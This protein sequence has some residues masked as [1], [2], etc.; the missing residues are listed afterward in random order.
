M[1]RPNLF[2]LQIGLIV[3]AAIWRC[4]SA[5]AEDRDPNLSLIRSAW[6]ERHNSIKSFRFECALEQTKK[7]VHGRT[8][9]FDRPIDRSSPVLDETFRKTM[10]YSF[11]KGKLSLQ[12]EG[13]EWDSNKIAKS[14]YKL[15]AAFS[16]D[17]NVLLFGHN[18]IPLAYV[19]H[20]TVADDQ[21][22]AFTSL[23]AFHLWYDPEHT[24]SRVGWE[25][26]KRATV[27]KSLRD[28][29]VVV[30]FPRRYG[31]SIGRLVLDSARSYLPIRFELGSGGNIDS[32]LQIEYSTE[33]HMCTPKSW[34]RKD[35]YKPKDLSS[36]QFGA[37][38]KCQV[39]A[40]LKDEQ[41]VV[42]FPTGTHVS[43]DF[44]TKMQYFCKQPDGS[45]K[46]I[47]P[48]QFGKRDPGA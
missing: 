18:D 37:A 2:K 32:E 38:L 6:N 8:D 48:E 31:R 35:Y 10:T 17:G 4:S 43:E 45:L 23:L 25:N 5:C 47:A 29:Q 9:K 15:N 42:S 46:P 14:S 3:L 27:Q 13:E 39:N 11:D 34:E 21:L 22:A 7:V 41:F 30:E 40:A 26:G 16:G 12:L 44:G 28:D 33:A 24:L 19:D 1:H 36:R 20:R